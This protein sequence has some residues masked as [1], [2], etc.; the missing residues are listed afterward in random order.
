MGCDPD[1]MNVQCGA[2]YTI[3]FATSLA[4]FL[5]IVQTCGRGRAITQ[6]VA[7]S[8]VFDCT[9]GTDHATCIHYLCTSKR[10]DEGTA[11]RKHGAFLEQWATTM[12]RSRMTV[13]NRRPFAL[14]TL[15]LHNGVSIVL[16]HPAGLTELDQ[17]EELRLGREDAKGEDEGKGKS[18]KHMACWCKK[19]DGKGGKEG[20]FE[21]LGKGER[22]RQRRRHTLVMSLFSVEMVM[23]ESFDLPDV[24]WVL[25][26][27]P[28]V[29]GVADPG[30][31]WLEPAQ[32]WELSR[33]KLS[34]PLSG[35]RDHAREEVKIIEKEFRRAY[36]LF[37]QIAEVWMELAGHAEGDKGKAAYGQKQS[38]MYHQLALNCEEAFGK[39]HPRVECSL[40]E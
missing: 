8:D 32:S 18:E 7:R 13:S 19:V 1:Y 14:C 23:I 21:R 31:S 16:H 37:I 3:H 26:L 5:D 10:V 35:P 38:A 17:G 25:T 39:V 36:R 34:Q 4:L 28:W 11:G 15:V 6:D 40:T 27:W 30:L 9:I 12:Y 22:S 29:P 2:L 33:A 20:P 24:C